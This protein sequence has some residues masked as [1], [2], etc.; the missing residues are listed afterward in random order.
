M[1]PKQPSTGLFV[2]LNKGHVVTKRELPPRPSDRKGLCVV[3]DVI[4]ACFRCKCC[5]KSKIM[6]LTYDFST[7]YCSRC[8][9]FAFDCLTEP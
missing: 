9:V 8:L 5:F 2:G 4:C 1:A 7:I 3:N 6:K